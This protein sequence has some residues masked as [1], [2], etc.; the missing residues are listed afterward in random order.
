MARGLAFME[1]M[2][3]CD[4]IENKKPFVMHGLQIATC[5]PPLATPTQGVKFHHS[6]SKS[7]EKG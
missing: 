7:P 3:Q 1:V 6:L 2:E 4:E 5:S